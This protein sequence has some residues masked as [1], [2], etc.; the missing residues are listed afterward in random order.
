MRTWVSAI[1]EVAGI[2]ADAL[3]G[4]RCVVCGD[5]VYQ[6]DKLAHSLHGCD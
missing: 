5:R 6:R 4:E 2:L 3:L 1:L